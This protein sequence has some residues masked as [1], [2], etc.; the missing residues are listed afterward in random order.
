MDFKM[1]GGDGRKGSL[2]GSGHEQK[3]VIGCI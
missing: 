1:A 3:E 2:S